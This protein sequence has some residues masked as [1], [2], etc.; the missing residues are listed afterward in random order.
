M[1]P[2]RAPE[3]PPVWR[4]GA[5]SPPR[6]PHLALAPGAEAPL[7]PVDLPAGLRGLARE[8]VALRQMSETL[9]VPASALEMRPFPLSAR[10][11]AWDRVL[12]VPTETAQAWRA[13]LKPGCIALLPDYLALPCLPEV[14]TVQTDTAEQ[15]PV[16]VRL[17]AFDGFS[18]ETDLALRL[19]RQADRP[20]AVL[21]LGPP[22]AELD[23]WLETLGAPVLSE[24]A[25]AA[26]VGG[27]RPLRWTE[28]AGGIDL[29]TPLGAVYDRLGQSLARWR[30][31]AA[32]GLL[33]LGLY[34]AAL[35]LETR[36]LQHATDR[37][38]ALTR[39]LVRAHFVPEGPLLDI[40]A[41]VQAAA[42]SAAQPMATPASLPPLVLL[43]RAA[44]LFDRPSIEMRQAEFRPETGLV[45][46]LT[47][48]DFA[49]L[50]ATVADLRGAGFLVEVLDSRAQ[51][52][53]GIAARLRLLAEP[54]T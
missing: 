3:R 41:Q 42:A 17:G 33:A 7:L 29:R 43:Q 28:A 2:R 27:A 47:A 48:A 31:P 5:A 32:L 25:E 6:G 9:G 19:L 35:G 14:W 23:A 16:T 11:S 10:R 37:L 49:G 8:R 24:P 34:L 22:S 4:I 15:G 20:R 51:Q 46:S 39:D 50:D 45:A 13:A 12:V 26:R 30:W 40:R 18:A 53:G 54:E 21:R 44:P 38:S 52:S 1:S 36:R